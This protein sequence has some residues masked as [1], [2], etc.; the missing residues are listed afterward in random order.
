MNAMATRPNASELQWRPRGTPAHAGDTRARLPECVQ[1]RIEVA[2]KLEPLFD[3]AGYVSRFLDEQFENVAVWL[4]G[5]S[6]PTHEVELHLSSRCNLDC[7][8]CIGHCAASDT[9]AQRLSD[10]ITI[11]NIDRILGG[12]LNFRRGS[13]RIERVRFSGLMGE[14]L[15][16]RAVFIRAARCL[17]EEGRSVGLFTNGLLIGAEDRE[18]IDVLMQLSY[19]HFSLDAGCDSTYLSLKRPHVQTILPYRQVLSAIEMLACMRLRNGKGPRLNVGFVITPENCREILKAAADVFHVGADFIRFKMEL[20]PHSTG[21]KDANRAEAE[22]LIREAEERYH[23]PPSFS[24]QRLFDRDHGASRNAARVSEYLEHDC[25]FANF[26]GTI[27]ADGK[28]YL[29]DHNACPAAVSMGDALRQDLNDIWSVASARGTEKADRCAS[30]VCPPSAAAL[31]PFLHAC[32]AAVQEYGCQTT[33]RALDRLRDG[34]QASLS[35]HEGGV[36]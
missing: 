12:I 25:P 26:F 9:N 29:C 13:L 5:D 24:V 28:V 33:I 31:N 3:Q 2:K 10:R 1:Q 36:L 23:W 20:H 7:R 30:R 6:F 17:I 14:P 18:L 21:A 22:A 35:A 34:E 15:V 8:H 4:S 32:R 27:G 11:Q 16:P 19:I